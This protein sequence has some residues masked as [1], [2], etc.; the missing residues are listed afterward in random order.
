MTEN[1]IKDIQ[2]AMEQCLNHSC[3][4]CPL[5]LRTELSC[6][7]YIYK[8]VLTYIERPEKSNKN[9]KRKIN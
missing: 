2:K 5:L 4:D 7:K 3:K 8:T 1:E 9:I 6:Y